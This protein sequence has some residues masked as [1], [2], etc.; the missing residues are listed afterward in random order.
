VGIDDYYYDFVDAP[1]DYEG[2]GRDS[3]FDEV[4][5]E[6]REIYESDKKGVYYVRQMQIKFEK[7]YFHWITYN[8]MIGLE[9]IGYLKDIRIQREKGT[10]ARFFIHKTNRYPMRRI[11]K[12]EKLIE[13][14]SDD[15]ITRSCGH[16]AEDLFCNSLALKGFIPKAKKVNSYSGE[17]WEQSGHDLDFVFEKDGIA[18]GCEIKNTLG[19]IDKEELEIKLNMCEYLKVKPLFIMRGS[20]KTYNKMIIDKGGFV[21]IF[22]T[23]IYEL[24]QA[25]LVKRMRSELGLPVDCPKA[26]P[27]GIIERFTKWHE[28]KKV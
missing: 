20:P 17:K 19:Y 9:K 18:Y 14:F 11:N 15:T 16:R 13:E 5:Q 21:L 12:M 22:G 24:S 7:K 27:D 28:K 4:Q 8:A 26:I 25:E 23:Q 10:S 6:I 2:S 3:Y 1:E